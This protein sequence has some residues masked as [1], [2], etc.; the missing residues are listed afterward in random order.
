MWNR[1]GTDPPAGTDT[2]LTYEK[3]PSNCRAVPCGAPSTQLVTSRPRPK[4]IR[5]V[6]PRSTRDALTI[7]TSPMKPPSKLCTTR[8]RPLTAGGCCGGA[9][10]GAWVD[11]RTDVGTTTGR[12]GGVGDT[13]G[14]LGG[15]PLARGDNPGTTGADGP[16]DGGACVTSLGSTGTRGSGN[17]TGGIR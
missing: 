14:A 3:P 13:V 10:R 15:G 16:D 8:Y 6:Q 9:G 4:W 11:G 12:T 2:P 7:S 1:N 5:T 17:P